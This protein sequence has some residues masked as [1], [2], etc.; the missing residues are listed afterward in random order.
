M[1]KFTDDLTRLMA[2]EINLALLFTSLAVRVVSQIT[3]LL[4]FPFSEAVKLLKFDFTY[5]SV[6]SDCAVALFIRQGSKLAV[7][8]LEKLTS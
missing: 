2:V 4:V 6:L 7:V 5:P 8:N 3:S 1:S